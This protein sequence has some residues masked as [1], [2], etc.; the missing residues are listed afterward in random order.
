[1]KSFSG[2]IC[3]LCFTQLSAQPDDSK[4]KIFPVAESVYGYTTYRILDGRKFPSNSMYVVTDDGVVLFDTPW[5]TTQFQ[6]L[7]DS[8]LA[9]HRKNVVLSVSTH[10]HDDRTAGLD[11]LKARGIKTFSS[12]MT[13]KLCKERGEKQAQ[14][15]FKNDTT[16]FVGNCKFETYYPGEGHTKDN[17][18][19]WLERE[20]VLYGGCLVKSS[21]NQGL[22]NIAD[23][24]LNIWPLTVKNVIRKYPAPRLVIPG[25]FGWAGNRG[26]QHTLELLEQAGRKSAR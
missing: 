8:I 25:H 17:I 16:F 18:V 21:E 20:Q 6:P 15:H 4:L 22:G 11:F 13:L 7:L 26:L 10:F 14:F 24:S 9:K 3:V 5:D 1:M 19:I 23:A 2:V 12:Q